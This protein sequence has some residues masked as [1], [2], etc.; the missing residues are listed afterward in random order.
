M[1]LKNS[2]LVVAMFACAIATVSAAPA[3]NGALAVPANRIAGLWGAQAAVGPCGSGV[4]PIAI[5]T[6][7]LFHAG[8]TVSE[9][10]KFPPAGVANAFGVPGINQ[11]GIGLG[12]WSYDPATDEYALH[13]QFDWY[14]G[15]IYHGYQTVDR[16][17]MLSADGQQAFGPVR[18]VR[19]AFDGSTIIE[20][21]GAAV[22][23]RL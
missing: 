17:I 2:L 19:Y 18:S 8:G 9:N 14:V 4:T 1:Y 13:L 20:V 3:T 21:C 22:S 10:P 11:R 7:L 5:N 16:E 6:T 15:G 23:Q 12:T